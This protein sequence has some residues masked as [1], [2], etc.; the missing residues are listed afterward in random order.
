M[1]EIS[2]VRVLADQIDAHLKGKQIAL[3]NLG[4][5]P[6]KFVW[7]NLGPEE[8]SELVRG[9]VIGST[10]VK[11]RWLLIYLEPGYCLVLGETG[12]KML[13]HQPGVKLPNAYHLLLSFTDGGALTLTVQMWG[14][15]ELFE[16]GKELQGKYVRDQA[17][18]PLDKEF[19]RDYFTSLVAKLA[20]EGKRGVKSLLT[21]EQ[22]IPGLGN[23]VAQDIMFLAG[24][25]PKQNL[26]G[27]SAT[28]VDRLYKCTVETVRE[29]IAKGGRNDETDLFGQSGKYI[30]IMHSK[31]AGKP[32]PQCGSMVQKIQYLG[33]ACYFCPAC[34]PLK[35]SKYDA[36]PS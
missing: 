35:D 10:L 6:H 14:G 13:W 30:R 31:A 7:H 12:G 4:N 20:A 8:F 18:T 2:E 3:G 26:A 32:C 5:S 21:Q 29:I 24:L 33:G 25:H 16:Q 36:C 19:S 11:G 1:F 22:T 15:I 27:L 9:K 28:D 34:Q 17:P 23:S